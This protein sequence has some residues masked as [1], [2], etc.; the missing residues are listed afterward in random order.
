MNSVK[1][2]MIRSL[3]YPNGE[4]GIVTVELFNDTSE[5]M[6]SSLHFLL[7]EADGDKKKVLDRVR[8]WVLRAP[9]NYKGDK[10]RYTFNIVDVEERGLPDYVKDILKMKFVNIPKWPEIEALM[11][12]NKEFGDFF[13][14][15][16]RKFGQQ[17]ALDKIRI[18]FR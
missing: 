13:F 14:S 2:F 16:K 11:H 3:I 6:K 9:A 15:L 12:E 7:K 8:K 4:K 1:Q 18:L 10:I 17:K 5:K